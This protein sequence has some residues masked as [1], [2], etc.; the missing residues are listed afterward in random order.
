MVVV[1]VG[2]A[3]GSCFNISNI[4]RHTH[5]C[6][7]LFMV[8]IRIASVPPKASLHKLCIAETKQD[9]PASKLVPADCIGSG[10]I[11]VGNGHWLSILHATRS[12]H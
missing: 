4:G 7:W 3:V 10:R 6:T 2:D 12:V 8:R 9:L 5:A 1:V 11:K